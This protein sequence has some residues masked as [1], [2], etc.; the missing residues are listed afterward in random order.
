MISV[1]F[2]ITLGNTFL[3]WACVKKELEDE[4]PRTYKWGKWVILIPPISILILIIHLV[5]FLL[6]GLWE[7]II[8]YIND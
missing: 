2:A 5:V 3:A 6:K 8:D 4:Y 7:E 1:I